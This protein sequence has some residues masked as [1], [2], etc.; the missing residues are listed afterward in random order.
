MNLERAKSS[1]NIDSFYSRLRNIEIPSIHLRRTRCREV[2]SIKQ[3]F[4]RNELISGLLSTRFHLYLQSNLL[5][6]LAS[7]STVAFVLPK[8]SCRLLIKKETHRRRNRN[9]RAKYKRY[10]ISFRIISHRN[11]FRNFLSGYFSEMFSFYR[12]TGEGGE[13]PFPS[14]HKRKQIKSSYSQDNKLNRSISFLLCGCCL[15]AVSHLWLD[16]NLF[17]FALSVL[18]LPSHPTW[19]ADC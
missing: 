17:S 3:F 9:G 13:R 4:L 12:L 8:R 15:S 2:N 6:S 5:L 1:I 11:N 7:L 10:N 19:D 16:S 18:R 14:L